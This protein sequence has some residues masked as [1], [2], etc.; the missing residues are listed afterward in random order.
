MEQAGREDPDW[1][2]E[3]RV[4]TAAEALQRGVPEDLVRQAYGEKVFAK[5]TA[6]RADKAAPIHCPRTTPSARN[7]FQSG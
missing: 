6:D 5:A 2:F 7:A 3:S 1:D 4:T